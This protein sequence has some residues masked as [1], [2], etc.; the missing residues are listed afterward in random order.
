MGLR[1]V[2][3]EEMQ[4]HEK[5]W[6]D[7]CKAVGLDTRW[8]EYIANA[9]HVSKFL[10]E[11]FYAKLFYNGIVPIHIKEMAQLRLSKMHGCH[12]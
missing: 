7:D 3:R 5:Q 8:I 2:P 4:E 1:R 11:D 10:W 9:P 6:L 12:F